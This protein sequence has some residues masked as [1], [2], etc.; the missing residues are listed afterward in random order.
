MEMESLYQ[1]KQQQARYH[2]QGL[3]PLR[4]WLWW[5]FLQQTEWVRGALGTTHW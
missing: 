1:N 5:D 4:L 2:C 3:G